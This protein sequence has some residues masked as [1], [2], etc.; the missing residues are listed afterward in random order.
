MYWALLASH[1]ACNAA[2]YAVLGKRC[3]RRATHDLQ[4]GTRWQHSTAQLRATCHATTTAQTA[5]A[6]AVATRTVATAA[7]AAAATATQRRVTE[8]QYTTT[9]AAHYA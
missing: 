8:T 6:T 2:R 9:T 5:V 4:I 1:Y 3:V 7:G